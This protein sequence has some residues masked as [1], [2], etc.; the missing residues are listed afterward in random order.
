MR[1]ISYAS[2]CRGGLA[3]ANNSYGKVCDIFNEPVLVEISKKYN[4]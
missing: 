3:S 2:L 4:K 1:V